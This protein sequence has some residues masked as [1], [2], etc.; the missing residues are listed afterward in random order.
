MQ[1][2]FKEKSYLAWE[3]L[4]LGPATLRGADDG[5]PELRWELQRLNKPITGKNFS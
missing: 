5:Q 2:K 1:K 3:V 4:P